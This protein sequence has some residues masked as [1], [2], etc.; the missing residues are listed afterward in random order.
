MAVKEGC[1]QL[2]LDSGMQRKDAHRFYEREGMVA[3][4]L[5]FVEIIA[6]N[7]D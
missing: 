3:E 5:H 2:H 6:P 7:G 1:T 4:G